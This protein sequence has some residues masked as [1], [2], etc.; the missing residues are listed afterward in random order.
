L[1]RWLGGGGRGVRVGDGFLAG[2]LG[3]AVGVGRVVDVH[4]RCR[5]WKNG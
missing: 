4:C 2:R 3:V 5:A 1:G